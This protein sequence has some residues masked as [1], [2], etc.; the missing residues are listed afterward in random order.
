M[1]FS[2]TDQI[3]HARPK[4]EPPAHPPGLTFLFAVEAW[5]RFAYYGMQALLVLYMVKFLLVGDRAETIIGLATLRGALEAL[6]GPLGVQPF[7][8]HVYG[9]YTALIALTPLIGGLVADRMLGQRRAVLVGG[10]LLAIGHLMMALEPLFLIALVI[11]VAGNAAFQPN[12]AT[13]VGSLYAPG[14]PHRDRA[15]SIFYM[16]VKAAAFLAPLLCVALGEEWG[17]HYGF[18]AAGLGMLIALA[19]YLYAAPALPLDERQKAAALPSGGFEWRSALAIAVLFLPAVLFWAAFEQQGNTIPLWADDSTDRTIDLI[20]WHGEIPI[21]W[22]QTLNPLL[23]LA[24]APFV[25]ARWSRQAAR[26]REPSTIG[27]MALGCLAMALAYLVMAGAAVAAGGDEA[28]WWWL[29]GYFALLSLGELYFAPAGLSLVSKA[30]P[31]GM[32]ST[33]MGIWF[34]SIF[35]G[36]Y[37]SGW[38]GSLWSEMTKPNFFLMLAGIAALAGAAIF[39]LDRPLRN[40]LRD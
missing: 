31:A 32:V 28:S 34:T 40:V 26:G 36:A 27:K 7:A 33:T 23:F 9:L 8:S 29:A 16:A 21:A 5:E 2:R 30:A 4:R 35:L 24:L 20:V 12:I 38:L 1:A 19:I 14:D 22:L 37:L 10:F 39:A 15:Y 13:Q 11:L 6:Y 18:A 17:W 3:R 25:I